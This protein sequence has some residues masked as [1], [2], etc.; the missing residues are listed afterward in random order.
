MPIKLTVDHPNRLVLGVASGVLTLPE[1]A[2]FA[3]D[4]VQGGLQPYRKLVDVAVATAGFSEREVQA[5]AQVVRELPAGRTPGPIAFV[6]DPGRGD[7][8]RMFT[9]LLGGDRT[10]MVFRSIHDARKWLAEQPV[11][12]L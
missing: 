10:T 7:I 9:G 1:M 12:H 3:R 4:V 5:F 6:A 8:A 11:S 2:A